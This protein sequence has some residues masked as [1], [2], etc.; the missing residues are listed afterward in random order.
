MGPFKFVYVNSF[1]DE[2]RKAVAS[3]ASGDRSGN[4]NGDN[5]QHDTSSNDIPCTSNYT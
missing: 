2:N 4:D 1:Q 3:H 5:V